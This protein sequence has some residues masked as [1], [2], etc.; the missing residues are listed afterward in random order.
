[1]LCISNV[2][3]HSLG[4][5]PVIMEEGG[6]GS[7]DPRGKDACISWVLVVDSFSL[8]VGKHI[9]LGMSIEILPLFG[10]VLVALNM[11]DFDLDRE[12]LYSLA[13]GLKNVVVGTQE[14]KCW[15]LEV[16]GSVYVGDHCLVVNWYWKRR[17]IVVC[18]VGEAG[19]EGF[20]PA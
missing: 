6:T 17:W 9:Y 19:E 18:M 14:V 7:S 5:V 10:A 13:D 20:D 11:E 8:F 12:R 2:L 1:M 16:D 15:S 4:D 3:V